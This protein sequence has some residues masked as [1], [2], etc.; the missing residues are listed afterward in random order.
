MSIQINS[1]CKNFGEKIIFNN[2]SISLPDTGIYILFGESGRGKT[3]LLRL[4]CGLDKDYTGCISFNEKNKISVAFQEYRLFPALSALDNVIFANFDRKS[5]AEIKLAEKSLMNLGITKEDFTLKPNELSGGM[6]QRISLARALTRN[7]DILLLDEPTKELDEKNAS[8][9]LNI[10]KE[11]SKT[12]LVIIVTHNFED[13][14]KL[15]AT[16]INI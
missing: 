1:L 7:F 6:K 12:K 8:N 11:I 15:N 3:T 2:F 9:V 14:L 10:I 5:E 13:A 4:I 16:I